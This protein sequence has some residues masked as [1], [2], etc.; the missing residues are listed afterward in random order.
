MDRLFERYYK[1][2]VQKAKQKSQEY[3]QRLNRMNKN[4]HKSAKLVEGKG[5]YT[6]AESNA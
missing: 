6:I 1:E 2:N 5:K 4:V 3:T